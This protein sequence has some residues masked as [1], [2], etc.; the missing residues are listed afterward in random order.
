MTNKNFQ[1]V[2]VVVPVYLRACFGRVVCS[3]HPRERRRRLYNKIPIPTLEDFAEVW[4][5]DPLECSRFASR[6]RGYKAVPARFSEDFHGGGMSS[7]R[8]ALMQSDV[9]AHRGAR[10]ASRSTA[11]AIG[12]SIPII[13]SNITS[14]IISERKRPA[15]DQ[16][17]GVSSEKGRPLPTEGEKD[18]SIAPVTVPVELLDTMLEVRCRPFLGSDYCCLIN[19]WYKGE[20]KLN[21]CA[22]MTLYWFFFQIE[23]ASSVFC[24]LCC[25]VLVA[26]LGK[27][28]EPLE[29]SKFA[30]RSGWSPLHV[31]TPAAG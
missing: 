10:R 21:P 11:A 8:R 18:S 7:T 12:T 29:P 16:K 27:T 9:E 22:R 31:F 4:V 28:G 13:S 19:P 6:E 26:A 23:V 14:S 25:A 5:L 30:A 17:L 20:A 24:V 2:L 1:L 15:S 3:V